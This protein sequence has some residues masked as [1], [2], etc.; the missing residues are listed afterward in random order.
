VLSLLLVACAGRRAPTDSVVTVSLVATTDL[1]G[2]L[3]SLPWLAGHLAILRAQR[4]V[5]LVDSGD[6][7]QGTL[8][9]NLGEGAAVV[10][11]YNALGYAAAALGNHEYDFGPAGPAHTPQYPGQD[12][13]GAIKQRAAEA[14]FALLAANVREAGQPG[15]LAW[16]NVRP[17]TVVSIGGVPIGVVGVVTADT[18][19][20]T[21]PRNFA[22]LQVL[23][24]VPAITEAARAARQAGAV[25]VVLAAHAGGRC[26]DLHDPD[27]LRSCDAREEIFAVARA[28]PPGTVDA[29]AAGHTHQAVAQRVA[30]IPIVQAFANGRALGRI[31]LSID[32]GQRR[33]VG[34]R[35]FPP[36][37]LCGGVPVPSFAPD[38]CHPPPFEGQPVRFDA[39]I[40]AVV[41]PDVARARG[42]RDQPV[43]ITLRTP[44]RR[45]LRAESPLGNLV[46]D[47]LR[48]AEPR[49]DLA[50]INGGSLRADLPAGPLRYG[51]LYE[52]LPFDDGLA[53]V[54]LDAARVRALLARNLERSQGLLSLSGLRATARCQDGAL[55]VTLTDPAGHEVPAD[56]P[57]LAVTNGYLASGGDGLLE[58][59]A[60]GGDPDP[61]PMRELFVR[62]LAARGGALGEDDPALYDPAHPRLAYPGERPL[63][64]PP[65]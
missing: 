24:L 26:A 21:H 20:S 2:R 16:P 8:E 42:K 57:L 34:H 64:C 22:G 50:F 17:W 15:S 30:G 19:R 56:R 46:A 31:D 40:A 53:T 29:I 51:Q 14:R 44:I 5:L 10:R 11:A 43:G 6:M 1:H 45:T 25:A 7:F 32:L 33:V 9:S 59:I 65:R 27:D 62:L 23:P 63:R 60:T 37:P 47:L 49:A 52:A 58:G 18:P 54:P 39:A 38:A 36:R 61:V 55:A 41:A 48:A 3:E 35:I 28:L 4:P 12:P 13:R